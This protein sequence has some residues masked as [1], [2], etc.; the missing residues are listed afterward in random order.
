[1]AFWFMR[2]QDMKKSSGN[3]YSQY[4]AR[5]N[6]AGRLTYHIGYDGAVF[7]AYPHRDELWDKIESIL[8]DCFKRTLPMSGERCAPDIG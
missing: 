7:S 5:I 3:N 4:H 6:A 8:A 2:F 1:M